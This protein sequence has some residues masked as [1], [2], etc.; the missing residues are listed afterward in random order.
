VACRHG[1]VS[2]DKRTHTVGAARRVELGA[3]SPHVV[4]MTADELTELA[5]AT[6]IK[7]PVWDLGTLAGSAPLD[8]AS[9]GHR[10]VRLDGVEVGTAPMRV[11][12]MP[13]RHTVEVA[14]SQGRAGWIDVGP[15]G[16]PAR[17]E[18]PPEAPVVPGDTA[19]NVEARRREFKAGLDRSKLAACTRTAAKSGLLAAGA[20][21]QIEIAVDAQGAVP[22]LNI[23]D[24]DLSHQFANCV[25]EVLK[26]VRFKAGAS[27][28]W[29]ERIEL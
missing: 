13:G 25:G 20:Y 19:S 1:L 27:A 29:N 5:D 12:V 28:T 2:I 3:P 21:V 17:I 6:P 11:R 15:K 14:D 18:I 8:I 26:G 10:E 24:T 4:A 23:L 9:A 22:F 7:M 16:K